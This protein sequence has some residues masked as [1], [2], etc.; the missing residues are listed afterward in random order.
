LSDTPEKPCRYISVK[1]IAVFFLISFAVLLPVISNASSLLYGAKS[2]PYASVWYNW[3]L[4]Y[5]Y[6]NKL[7]PLKVTAVS[8]PYGADYSNVIQFPVWN[9]INKYFSI[10]AS[11]IFAY[12]F[13]IFFSFLLSGIIMYFFVLYLVKQRIPALLSAVIYM[14]CPYHFYHSWDHLSLAQI[15][16]I[17]LYVLSL[18]HL[19]NKRNFK[20]AILCGLSFSLVGFFD[21]YYLFYSIIVSFLFLGFTWFYRHRNGRIK[22]TAWRNNFNDLKYVAV[23]I[24]IVVV[25]LLP[26][27][28]GI[29]KNVVMSP[30]GEQETKMAKLYKRPFGQLFAD[31]ARPFDYI[32]PPV[33]HP[34]MGKIT[35]PFQDTILY[36]DNPIEH[37]LFLGFLPLF[38]AGYAINKYRKKQSDFENEKEK[39]AFSFFIFLFFASLI[40]S[41]PP[42]IPLGKLF[43]PFPSFFLFK[44]FPMFRNYARFGLIAMISVSV[45]AGFGL[46]LFLGSKKSK[47]KYLWAGLILLAIFFEFLLFPNFELAN[48]K[49][50]PDAYKWL[51]EQKGDIIIGEY[52]LRADERPYLFWQHIHEKKLVNGAVPGSYAYEVSQKII[53]LEAPETAGILSHMGVKY[54]FVHK[55]RYRAYEGGK[56]LGQVPDLSSDKRYELVKSFKDVDVYSINAAKINPDTV[57][58]TIVQKK[59]QNTVSP[60]Q[61]GSDEVQQSWEYDVKLFNKISLASGSINIGNEIRYNNKTVI[62]IV[63]KFKVVPWLSTIVEAEATLNSFVDKKQ[64]ATIR[65]D[66]KFIVNK[67]ARQKEALFDQKQHI[68]TTK[69]REVK[70]ESGAQDPLSLLYFLS[71]QDFNINK[72]F[73]LFVNPGKS[74]YQLNIQVIDKETIKVGDE[75][76]TC[77]K[78]ASELF[79]IKDKNKKI[80]SMNLWL[81]DSKEQKPVKIK[82]ITKMGF[83]DINLINNNKED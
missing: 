24:L 77:W 50:P 23:I 61:I 25:F 37:T 66:E 35:K 8:A 7:D 63:A 55:D 57:T 46:K 42:Y 10:Y 78:L 58:V 11:E 5:S 56:I 39:F 41:L 1:M 16:W 9:F 14:L 48:A 13:M 28:R 26:I 80:L 68:M 64:S 36:G 4:K 19:Y 43:I 59:I 21:F 51:Q 65:Y 83:I 12:N 34:V 82:A 49:N 73:T 74:N 70:I 67:K 15:Q 79:K 38:L 71:K 75:E 2:D 60:K 20:N 31:S 18:L 44:I 53:D 81:E 45:G 6:L 72:E 62:P 40:I 17:P 27:I 32:L 30:K 69:D 76:Y 33:D 52:P 54:V 47:Q 29:I 3:W 22:K